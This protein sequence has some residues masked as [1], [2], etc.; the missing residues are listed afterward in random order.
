MMC[1]AG[2]ST[3]LL[4]RHVRDRA[5]LS[6]E[7]AV[8]ELTGRQAE[9]FGLRGRGVI[10]TG[11][12]ADLTVF[13]P[14][15][16]QWREEVLTADLPG[17]GLRLRRPPGGFRFTVVAGTVVQHDGTLTGALPGIV[18]HPA[19]RDAAGA[20][21]VTRDDPEGG[22]RRV[23][24]SA[25]P[26]PHMTDEPATGEAGIIQL[27]IIARGCSGPLSDVQALAAGCVAAV[28]DTGF[29]IV[30]DTSY[31]F[32]PHGATVA[33]VLAQSHLVVS[34]WPE[35]RFAIADLTICG[36]KA[37]ALR[38]WR[39]LRDVLKPEDEEITEHPISFVRTAAMATTESGNRP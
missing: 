3:L 33:L 18:L 37:S 30:A 14:A 34:T 9:V 31:A 16:L 15:A 11:Y 2:D 17:G 19:A 5:D 35:Y 20:G 36:P 1:T 22:G 28:R 13:D 24:A 21:H 10:A 23:G 8:R 25:R 39:F 27:M 12:A 7:H 32:T 6:V 29:Q 26:R 38:L 4:A